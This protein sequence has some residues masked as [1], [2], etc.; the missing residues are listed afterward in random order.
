M[1]IFC[2]NAEENQNINIANKSSENVAKFKCFGTTV[3]NR[4]CI[5]EHKERDE[6]VELLLLPIYG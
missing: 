3:T 2:Q 4:I 1:L 6:I 5:H